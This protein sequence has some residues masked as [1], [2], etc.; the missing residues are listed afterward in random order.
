MQGLQDLLAA[1]RVDD[2][3]ARA[4]AGLDGVRAALRESA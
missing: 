3:Q 1:G 2:L 4:R